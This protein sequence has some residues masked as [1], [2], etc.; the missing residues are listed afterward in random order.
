MKKKL[1]LVT[2]IASFIFAVFLYLFT[3][4]VDKSEVNQV[5]AAL[6]EK[7]KEQ[8]SGKVRVIDGDSLDIEGAKIR[9]I[10]IDAPEVKQTCFNSGGKQYNCGLDS[11]KFLA[12]IAQDKEGKCFYNKKDIYQRFLAVCVVADIIVNQ[13]LLE[14]GMAVIY[15]YSKPDPVNFELEQKARENKIGIWQ[16]EFQLPKDYRKSKRK[17]KKN[18]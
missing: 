15:D 14:S 16:G 17:P 7:Y 3:T 12:D 13:A 2:I 4:D 6:L 11:K 8:L 18:E 1:N 10:G 9:L 5:E